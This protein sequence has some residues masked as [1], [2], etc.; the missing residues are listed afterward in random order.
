MKSLVLDIETRYSIAKNGLDLLTIQTIMFDNQLICGFRSRF[1][2]FVSNS[3]DEQKKDFFYRCIQ[4]KF[5]SNQVYVLEKEFLEMAKLYY[6]NTQYCPLKYKYMKKKIGMILRAIKLKQFVSLNKNIHFKN[7]VNIIEN[8]NIG[9][10]DKVLKTH[11]VI[12][13]FKE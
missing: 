4:N 7:M 10:Y 8:N 6:K 5:G 1:N 12:F 3:V 11:K 13:G 2:Y 9:L